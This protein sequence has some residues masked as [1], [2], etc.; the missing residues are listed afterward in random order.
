MK[1][2]DNFF[3]TTKTGV[4]RKVKRS[5]LV[6]GKK[7]A[8]NG[9]QGKTVVKKAAAF[10]NGIVLKGRRICSGISSLMKKTVESLRFRR[11]KMHTS[12]KDQQT[13]RDLKK[14]TWKQI[15]H[16]EGKFYGGV[17]A[18]AVLV[19]AVAAIL[20]SGILLPR[21]YDI[22][23]ND[24]G[25]VVAANTTEKTVGAFLE[26]NGIIL[27]EGDVLVTDT[28]AELQDGMEIVIK[29]A[30][31]VDITRG[32]EKTSIKM[33]AGTVQQALDIAGITLGEHDEVY[34]VAETMISSGTE[35]TIIEVEEQTITED[36]VLYYKEITK[37]DSTLA[38]GKTK[39][40]QQGENGLERHTIQV[41]YK[42]GVE[43]SRTVIGSEVIKE[44]VDEITA[45][46]TYVAPK[47]ENSS[48]GQ[49]SN[50]NQQTDNSAG[51]GN[52]QASGSTQFGEINDEGKLVSVPTITQIHTG[53][54]YEHKNAPEPDASIIAKT[55]YIDYVTAYTWT[56][57]PTATG[58]YPK[59]GTVAADPAKFAYGT[60]VYVPG[61]GYGRIE[62]TGGFRGKE[63]TQF[64]LYMDSESDCRTWGRKR[65]YKVYI[66]K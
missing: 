57:N 5:Q 40:V 44:A 22:L 53:N 63:Y 56:G 65:G 17:T 37:N 8:N 66:L 1:K 7:V 27:G 60:K 51:S 19:I 16:R 18:A 59:I 58:V 43:V 10:S 15:F 11:H 6:E 33:L 64:D 55:V 9:K 38:K 48:S 36:E 39:L 20:C 52:T 2:K 29:R 3:Q 12:T 14:G 31:A 50:Q 42:N 54:L 49:S 41:V 25:R 23:V 24:A 28:Q 30:F 45:I 21:E 13:V 32:N 62:D 35:I 61:Y 46:G 4:K 26:K 47:Q 34:P